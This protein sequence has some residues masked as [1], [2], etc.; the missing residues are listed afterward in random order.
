MD[1]VLYKAAEDGRME[2]F[3]HIVDPLDCL[4]TIG[5]NTILHIYATTLIKESE[6]TVAFVNAILS[7]CRSLL[8]K[9]NNKGETPLHIA[10]RSDG[11][12]AKSERRNAEETE[13]AKKMEEE[14]EEKESKDYTE[15][16]AGAH[17]VVAALITTVTFIAGITIPGGFQ[18]GDDSHPGSAV[19]MGSAA[20]RAFVVSNE[21]SC[22]YPLV[23]SLST[24]LCHC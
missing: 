3:E 19:L 6:S 14:A 20:F 8:W 2:A 21:L 22:C 23:L 1:P 17:L 18:S 9:T 11:R 10:A 4:R 7:K 12:I 13:K 15:K 16:A 5:N 24:Y